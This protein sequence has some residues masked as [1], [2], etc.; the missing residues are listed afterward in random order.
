MVSLF[1]K[2]LSKKVSILAP[3]SGQLIP[4]SSVPDKVFSEKIMGDG[5]AIKPVDNKL[6]SPVDGTV[7]SVFPTKHAVSLSSDDGLEMLLHFGIDTVELKGAPFDITI[8][9]GQKIKSGDIIGSMNINQVVES[10]K[11][12]DIIIVFT[13]MAKLKQ[14]T[15]A[16]LNTV[17][18]GDE[19]G[20]VT[21]A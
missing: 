2:F 8:Q 11:S 7:L 19:I 4:L 10:G 1:K 20:T 21:L 18:H 5:F 13:N 14:V 17:Q 3:V 16:K 12:S 6:Y 9:Q 15:V